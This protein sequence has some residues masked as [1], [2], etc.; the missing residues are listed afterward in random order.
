[1]MNVPLIAMSVTTAGHSIISDFV[2]PI[3]TLKRLRPLM[4]MLPKDQMGLGMM[5][6]FG[7]G[8]M[9]PGPGVGE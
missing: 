5:K 8:F 2:L 4:E 3:E 1:M 9:P 6:D 7:G